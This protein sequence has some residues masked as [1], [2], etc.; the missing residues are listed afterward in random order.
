MA[1]KATFLRFPGTKVFVMMLTAEGRH[2]DVA[3]PARPLKRISCGP[4][5]DNPQASVNALCK[6]LPMKY[7]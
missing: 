7:T 3:I 2:M 6:A 4:L 5:V 1:A